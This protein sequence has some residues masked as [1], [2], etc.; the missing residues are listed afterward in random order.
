MSRGDDSHYAV[1]FASCQDFIPCLFKR[2]LLAVYSLE[3]EDNFGVKEHVELSQFVTELF[4]KSLG[5]IFRSLVTTV[6]QTF[7]LR[8]RWVWV[9]FSVQSTGIQV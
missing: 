1:M 2:V 5:N 7:L 4:G 9:S 3:E 8:S 6:P